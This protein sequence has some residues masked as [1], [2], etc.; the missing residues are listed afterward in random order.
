M[1]KDKINKKWTK[2][3]NELSKYGHETLIPI[4]GSGFNISAF[5]NNY[6]WNRLLLEVAKR[7]GIESQIDLN[8]P[9]QSMTSIWE[10]MIIVTQQKIK[11][12]TLTTENFL[13]KTVAECLKNLETKSPTNS[14][15]L[16]EFLKLRI[17]DILK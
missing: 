4:I 1:N 7:I 5:Q 14:D 3:N 12:P 9:M 8:P 2:F 15:L 10:Q 11:K 16:S 17:K 13:R 6:D